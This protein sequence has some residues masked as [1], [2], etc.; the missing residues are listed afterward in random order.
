MANTLKTVRE[1]L[2]I[3]VMLL[4]VLAILFVVWWVNGFVSNRNIQDAVVA[5]SSAVRAQVDTRANELAAQVGALG[6]RLEAVERKLDR[7]EGKID[8]LIEFTLRPLGDG[9]QRAE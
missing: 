2:R 3:A 8:R 9:L 5:E 6:T 4:L 7:I 1:A